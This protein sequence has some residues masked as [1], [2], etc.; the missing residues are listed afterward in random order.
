MASNSRDEILR[1][2]YSTTG[3]SDLA[4]TASLLVKM[5]DAGKLTDQESIALAA[6]LKALAA[7]TKA[8]N[9][10]LS[11][12]VGL[13]ETAAQLKV[14]RDAFA[15]LSAET[16]VAITS[17]KRYQLEVAAAA[18]SIGTLTAQQN[19][20]QVALAKNE[21]LLQKAGIDTANLGVADEQL[22]L[23]TAG[24]G[25]QLQEVAGGL[26]ATAASSRAAA[27]G[28]SEVAAKSTLLSGAI[29]Q[30]KTLLATFVGFFV[31]TQVKDE[32]GAILATGDKF[33]KWGI[34]FTNAF[35]G[36]E[37][38]R[39][40]LANVKEI[41][42]QTP[43]S[44]EQVTAAAIQAKKVGLDPF[45]GSLKALIDTTAK[46]GGSAD[47][48]SSL[49]TGL[50]RAYNRGTLSGRELI[51]LQQEGIPV[52]KLLGEAM[53]KSASEVEALAKQGDLGRD[54]IRL[55][56]EQLG[57]SSAGDAASQL[58]LLGSQVVKVKDQW[59]LFLKLIGDSGAYDFAR[60]KMADFT[61][62]IKKGLADG[63][64]IAAAQ[65]ISDAI[66]GIGRA[67]ASV[68]KFV[69]DHATAIGET[70]KAYVLFKTTLL[71]LDLA[72]AAAKM[73][74]LA[75][76]TAAAGA[77]ADGATA[78]G[79]ARLMTRL[80]ALPKA[81][82]IGIA[83]VAV[84][85]A[86]TQVESLIAATKEYNDVQANQK[87]LDAD[88]GTQR[89]QLAAKAGAIAEQ[90]KGF[91]DVQVASAE[92]L[93]SKTQE[94]SQAYIEQ[95]QNATRYYTALRIQAQQ[96]G[97]S[98]GIA[99][100]TAE[101]K[102]LGQGLLDAQSLFK[103]VGDEIAKTGASAKDV[104]DDFLRLRA[105][106]N[107]AA[108]SIQ[109]SF[110]AIDVR[111]PQGLADLLDVIKQIAPLSGGARDAIQSNLVAALAKLDSVDLL[112]F[113]RNIT[114]KL[115][116]AK[117]KADELTIALRAGLEA[118][119]LNL[120]LSAQQAGGA[121]S[122]EGQKMIATFAAIADNAAASGKLIQLAFSQ[123]IS[124]AT[125]S[126][127]IDALQAKLSQAFA[128]GK[129]SADAFGVAM[130]AAGRK[131]AEIKSGA[132]IASASLDGVGA[133]GEAAAARISGALQG[134]RGTL[135]AQEDRLGA[136]LVAAL[137][138]ND[139]TLAD[140]LNADIKSVA[141]QVDAYNAK[142]AGLAPPDTKPV[143]QA[144]H[145]VAQANTAVIDTSKTAQE[146]LTDYSHSL[147]Y[148]GAI[149]GTFFAHVNEFTA[150]SKEAGLAY[151]NLA[152]QIFDAGVVM[153]NPIEGDPSHLI[154]FTESIDRAATIMT[155]RIG[156]ALAS[157]NL[158]AAGYANMSDAALLSMAKQQSG[159][160]SM[161]NVLRA[162]AQQFANTADAAGLLGK[163]DMAPLVAGMDAAAA[164]LDALQ[165]KAEQTKASFL[166]MASSLSDQIDQ[167]N[168]QQAS[169]EDRRYAKQLADMKAQ[170]DA[171]GLSQDAAYA[172]AVRKADE[173]HRLKMQ[174]IADQAAAS[175][176]AADAS[177]AQATAAAAATAATPPAASAAQT[178]VPQR[179][180]VDISGAGSI[181]LNDS[182]GLTRLATA[183]LPKIIDA[184][185][186][187]ARAT[188]G[189]H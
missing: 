104:I 8:V 118:E 46:Y 42:D 40:A 48:L 112:N 21:G 187:A 62:F 160:D 122:V 145:N 152:K 7:Q 124:K 69:Y 66:V 130:E 100:A 121:I 99:A 137:A 125:T 149:V 141:A 59:E 178:A 135:V 30:I 64:L 106:G 154:L 91:A 57:K 29:N 43:L 72:G 37:K 180:T 78:G 41:A 13:S 15:S 116:E 101:L 20:Q 97:D 109:H 83:I 93:K 14:A 189:F 103:A 79:Y 174:Q 86:L 65:G 146:G 61:A 171:V 92:Q 158:A 60:Q 117:G 136:Q 63:S 161:G 188:G 147:D 113:Q 70:I 168:G 162:T 157:M 166:D 156:D 155:Q 2:V 126:G 132:E 45:D 144:L 172:D 88:I 51:K 128:A 133:A 114:A 127:D 94:Q 110:G 167:I 115:A 164:R 177:A 35:G 170:A 25:V 148:F 151:Q 186:A 134:A 87:Q 1:F 54:S 3:D 159:Y 123:A 173:L 33:A 4:N 10:A 68:T 22:R 176:K 89:E 9:D 31:L 11:Q 102:T 77:A 108:T 49:I 183:L 95:L 131:T 52:T 163:A 165:Q 184:I 32:I 129:I 56:I 71:A 50:G 16:D 143:V 140:S 34:D 28:F 179:I 76:A 26:Q 150:H 119:L 67:A 39:V 27:T 142:I 19:L 5:A 111:T 107:D 120:G 44:L 90:L 84:D 139:Q 73:Y 138:A 38:G 98:A 23:K 169:I 80:N 181:N 6:S 18:K 17:S 75:T 96:A 12:K 58:G 85:F 74:T 105:A 55:L 24:L 182:V 53:G 185:K 47:T 82:Q 81:I 36:A 153:S 175:K